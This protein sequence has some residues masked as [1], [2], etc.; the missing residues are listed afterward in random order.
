[1]MSLIGD[2]EISLR[3]C[4]GCDEM[5][6]VMMVLVTMLRPF[7]VEGWA[8]RQRQVASEK[9]SKIQQRKSTTAATVVELDVFR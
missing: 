9:M 4:H 6:L 3:R 8:I 5:V 2:E 1:M 7:L